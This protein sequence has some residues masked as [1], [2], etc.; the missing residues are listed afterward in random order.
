MV[1][2]FAKS[3]SAEGKPRVEEYALD[4]LAATADGVLAG[5]G[6]L[7]AGLARLAGAGCAAVTLDEAEQAIAVQG[8]ELLRLLQLCL[9][10]QAAAE[11]RVAGVAGADGV[12]RTRA[13]RGHGRPV[14]TVL[15]QVRVTRI[16]YRSGVRIGKWQ[17][18]QITIAAAADAEQFCQRLPARPGSQDQEESQ[19]REES[20]D[21]E[22]QGHQEE[23][24]NHQQQEEPGPLVISAD[25][26]GVAM[27]PEARRAAAKAPDQR[28]R[29]FEHHRGTG[30]KGHNRCRR[31][32]QRGPRARR[33]RLS[34][35][36]QGRVAV[37]V[38]AGERA[39]GDDRRG[40]EP[41]RA[42]S[43]RHRAARFAA[44]HARRGDV[45]ALPRTGSGADHEGMGSARG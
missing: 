44:Y 20:Q 3:G 9:D 41:D 22:R 12:A 23:D 33:H 19:E 10:T 4:E 17:A 28:S 37:A 35:R 40:Q 25:G 27:R 31:Q 5:L 21:Q 11:V 26:K 36:G 34:C 39:A 29:T 43:R 45:G 15:G 7:A 14:V 2:K 18:E 24:Q 6:P 32:P 1:L 42:R 13:E 38:G 30:E 16:A 8:R